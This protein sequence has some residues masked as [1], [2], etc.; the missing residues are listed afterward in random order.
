MFVSSL[1]ASQKGFTLKPYR[2]FATTICIM[3]GS[4]SHDVAGARLMRKI[5]EVSKEEVTFVG[6]GGL[7]R[8]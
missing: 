7:V 8:P 4:P 1:L 2:N 5:K 3:A 6:L